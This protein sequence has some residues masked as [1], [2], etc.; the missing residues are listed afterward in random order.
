MGK[1]RAQV[2][3]QDQPIRGT[4]HIY[5]SGQTSAIP[6]TRADSPKTIRP[7]ITPAAVAPKG[8]NRDP[9][10]LQ[11]SDKYYAN[12]EGKTPV[13]APFVMKEADAA[14]AEGGSRVLPVAHGQSTHL[15][16]IENE[17]D[18]KKGMQEAVQA[19]Q[20]GVGTVRV[21]L[22]NKDWAAAARTQIEYA[23]TREEITEDQGRDVHYG[24][25]P[26][27]M[28]VNV[29]DDVVTKAAAPSEEEEPASDAV[30]QDPA[31]LM[32]EAEEA[33]EEDDGPEV[34]E[35]LDQLS[36]PKAEE[37]AAEEDDSDEE[38]AEEDDSEEEPVEEDDSEEEPEIPEETADSSEEDDA[39]PDDTD[40]FEEDEE[41]GDAEDESTKDE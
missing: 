16:T 8:A 15:V 31:D 10:V 39:E 29:V 34:D 13:P 24:V 28:D 3:Q 22:H 33:D 14:V 40:V 32:A 25:R 26:Q 38:P 36:Q 2:S 6:R 5:G 9:S 18:I 41:S 23:V 21:L 20:A 27:H 1:K 7:G 35:M 17:A 19:L 12:Q 30:Q 37:P 4:D 11:S